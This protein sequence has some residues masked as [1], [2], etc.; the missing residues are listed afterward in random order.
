MH[1][2]IIIGGGPAGVSA[3]LTARN[4]GKSVLIISNDAA[5]SDLYKSK[6]IN[7]YPGLPRVSG[8][9]LLDNFRAQ[10]LDAG[11]EVITARAI[12]ALPFGEKFFVSVGMDNYECL[13]LILAT[14]VIRAAAFPGEQEFLGRGVS[15]CATCDGM[16]Y[17][18]KRVAVIGLN[19]EAEDE[20]RALRA[21]GCEV[22]YF[23]KARAKNFEIRGAQTVD[24]LV[25]DGEEFPV[26]GVF[27]LRETISPG[28]F[29]QGLV[30]EGGH[31][32]VNER[33]ETSVKGVFA[34]GDCIGR[35]YQVAR[36][37]GQG[38]TAAIS[39]CEYLDA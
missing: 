9:Q 37:V 31:I 19:A 33:M 4:R 27:V 3:A 39:A 29:M 8:A 13:S 35:P 17:R 11:A 5:N 14:G 26:S 12:S 23:D 18:G 22:E 28:S 2:I 21:M 25:A 20:A 24:T 38:N 7:N 15:Y 6:H 32:A 34:A 10:A 36:A 30:S 16:L 1:D